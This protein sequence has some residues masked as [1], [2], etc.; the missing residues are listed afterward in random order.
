MVS[1]LH[2]NP[3]S[4]IIRVR[5]LNETMPE[6]VTMGMKVDGIQRNLFYEFSQALLVLR[7]LAKAFLQLTTPDERKRRFGDLVLNL[8][9]HTIQGPSFWLVYWSRKQTERPDYKPLL[10][11]WH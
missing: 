4:K 2:H 5:T 10:S 1:N 7:L 3:L 9:V 6:K 8:L 11:R